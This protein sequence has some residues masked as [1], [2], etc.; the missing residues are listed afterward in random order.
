M[1]CR[2]TGAD[3]AVLAQVLRQEQALARWTEQAPATEGWLI[4][5]SDRAGEDSGAHKPPPPENDDPEE[6][7]PG[8]P[9][10]R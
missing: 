6:P 8:A 4:A 5:A 1:I 9:H 10:A 3:A 2:R 7:P